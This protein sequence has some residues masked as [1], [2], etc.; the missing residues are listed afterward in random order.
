MFMPRVRRGRGSRPCGVSLLSIA[1]RPVRLQR[2][3]GAF[4][5]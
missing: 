2:R 3:C 5:P 1:L 4:R